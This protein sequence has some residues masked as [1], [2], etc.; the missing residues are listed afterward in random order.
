VSRRQ[1]HIGYLALYLFALFT[2]VVWLLLGLLPIL[3]AVSPSFHDWMHEIGRRGGIGGQFAANAAQASHNATAGGQVVL[4]YIFSIFNL[5]LSAVLMRLRPKDR[6]ASLLALGMVG[7]AVAFNLQGHDALQ[8]VPVGTLGVVTAWHEMVH[9]LSGVAYTFALLTFPDGELLRSTGPMRRVRAVLLGI[10][11]FFF[12]ILSLFTVE[13]HTVGLVIVFGVFI[14]VAGL[15]AQ[16]LRYRRAHNEEER[17][18]SRLLLWALGAATFIAIPLMFIT[19][20]IETKPEGTTVEYE[21][22]LAE[23]GVYFYRC[24]PHPVDMVGV[25]TVAADGPRFVEIQAIDDEFNMDNFELAAARNNTIRFTNNDADLHNVA[26]YRNEDMTDPVFV[27]KEFSGQPGGIVAF[28]IFRVVF[29][30]IPIAL[31]V[32]LVRFRMWD[33]NRV[34]NRTLAY[35]LIVGFV[36][37]AY[38]A[39]VLIVG[40]LVGR[41]GRLGLVLSIAV[42]VVVAAVFQ[43]VRD[44]ARRLANKIVYG[45]R[46]TPYEVLSEF[47]NRVGAAPD[48][49]TV[50][51]QLARI[52]AEGTGAAYSEVWLRRGSRL[53]RTA[54]WPEDEVSVVQSV[55]L[56]DGT[57]TLIEGR[58]RVV[59]VRHHDELL[60]LLAVAKPLGET[61]TPVEERLLDDAA[62]Q[63]GLALKNVQ[64]TTE[65]QHRLDE[66]RSSRQR[67][68]SAQDAERR[69]LERDIHD[70]AQQN[71]V[72]LSLKL[73]RAQELADRDP[74]KASELMEE[75]QDDTAEA[76]QALR[77]LA[78]GIHPPVLTDRGLEAALEAHARRCPLPVTVRAAGIGRHPAPI[79]AAV[80]FCASEAIQ[81]AVKH[82]GATNLAI[83]VAVRDGSLEFSITDDGSGF[84]PSNVESSG[85]ANMTDRLAAVAGTLVIT[86][87]P[88]G[89][90]KVR[91][92]IP[93]PG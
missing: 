35:G 92:H 82:S 16:A 34:V 30:L 29:A 36:S 13:D 66:L 77:D 38:L 37:L 45:K 46:A 74:V 90:T 88:G 72:A 27:G 49:E 61:L 69:R 81:N 71:L 91:G 75:L 79:E 18:R 23:P 85:I 22:A 10:A 11:A 56:P 21:V 12:T 57:G 70:G 40:A 17:Q 52:V 54:A 47:S 87:A 86:P 1:A 39:L 20:A 33:V 67:I 15:I 24:D 8:V 48:L 55:P 83:E 73:R 64:L 44:R 14:P 58:D 68:V 5:A 84:E 93:L 3:G 26:I 65:L 7:S 43:P 80:Y 25:V 9:V 53:V 76:L 28:R 41:G 19:G 50:I 2:A 6:T 32:G 62:A 89:G 42:T 60:G 78:R 63:V 59:E 31:I 4:D 51:P